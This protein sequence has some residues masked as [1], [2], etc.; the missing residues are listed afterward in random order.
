MKQNNNIISL[1]I[2]VIKLTTISCKL[3]VN[4]RAG[5]GGARSMRG[6]KDLDAQKHEAKS[7]ENGAGYFIDDD[8]G[9]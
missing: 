9:F 2:A 8:Q 7:N 4:A 6:L 3:V 5:G 1:R